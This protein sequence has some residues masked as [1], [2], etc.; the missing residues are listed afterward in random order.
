MISWRIPATYEGLSS[1]SFISRTESFSRS[2]TYIQSQSTIGFGKTQSSS[3][4]VSQESA[5]YSYNYFGYGLYST[6][7]SSSSLSSS[8]ST[9]LLSQ[10]FES[11]TYDDSGIEGTE[12]VTETE[13]G[14]GSSSYS[15]SESSSSTYQLTAYAETS[16]TTTAAYFSYLLSSTTAEEVGFDE[17]DAIGIITTWT[18]YTFSDSLLATTGTNTSSGMADVYWYLKLETYSA[19]SNVTTQDSQTVSYHTWATV[20]Q[21]EDNEIIYQIANPGSEWGGYSAARPLADSAT[22]ITLYPT[23]VVTEAVIA[24]ASDTTTSSW[25][26]P[27]LSSGLSLKTL[28]SSSFPQTRPVNTTVISPNTTTVSS[29]RFSTRSTSQQFNI[30]NS[31]SDTYGNSKSTTGVS[32]FGLLPETVSRQWQNVGYDG[33]ITTQTTASLSI[34]TIGAYVTNTSTL[35]SS[36]SSE[37]TSS[38][39][40]LGANV[41][42]TEASAEALE[43]NYATQPGGNTTLSTVQIGVSNVGFLNTQQFRWGTAGVAVGNSTGGWFTADKTFT[44]G[45]AYT[46]ADGA[47]RRVSTLAVTSNSTWTLSSNSLSYTTLSGADTTTTTALVG[48]AGSSFIQ[49]DGTSRPASAYLH[50]GGG[51]FAAGWT[52]VDQAAV[53]AYSDIIGNQTTF[54]TGEETVYTANQTAAIRRFV[55]IPCVTAPALVNQK[56]GVYWVEKKNSYHSL[57]L[58]QAVPVDTGRM[59]D[60]RF[61]V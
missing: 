3:S 4:S 6:E 45:F 16:T 19:A 44:M 43:Y 47:R 7:F 50:F 2:S 46:V 49:E 15:T 34:Y 40:G 1:S 48:V 11:I 10:T 35:Q 38:Y 5:L 30:F 61:R 8:T 25:S 28:A 31:A 57:Y 13:T 33:V 12:T 53:G 37:S 39:E 14:S 55:P 32:Q 22:R 26:A 23:A 51:P 60:A 52:V 18:T 59:V 27:G 42:W 17:A 20:V 9:T 58:Y 54:F 56:S 24:A 29:I 36:S 41:S 21:A